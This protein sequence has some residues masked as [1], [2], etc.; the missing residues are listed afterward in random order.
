MGEVRIKPDFSTI[1][2]LRRSM[3][4]YRTLFESAG[5]AIFVFDGDGRILDVNRVACER[6]GYRYKE[7]TAL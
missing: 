6:L 7:L 5:D 4:R 3:N 2:A 1:H